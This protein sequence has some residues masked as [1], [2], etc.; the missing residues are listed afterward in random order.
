MQY[1]SVALQ[2]SLAKGPKN[3]KV[4]PTTSRKEKL[5]VKLYGVG[6]ID[7]RPSTDKLHHFVNKKMWHM[8]CDMWYMTCDTLH[9]TGGGGGGGWRTDVR[10][11]GQTSWRMY[12]HGGVTCHLSTYH[13][14]VKCN[15]MQPSSKVRA[16]LAVDWFIKNQDNSKN[17]KNL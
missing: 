9:M 8:T 14:S 10:T 5:I 16:S 13:M 17:A 2:W 11:Y 1:W 3:T 7:Y 4:N 15:A 6:P 12:R